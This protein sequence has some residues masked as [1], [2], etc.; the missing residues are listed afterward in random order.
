M[1]CRILTLLFVSLSAGSAIAQSPSNLLLNPALN[2]HCF[3]NSR[4]GEGA[5]FK[6]GSIACWDV[7]TYGDAEAYRAARQQVFRPGFAVD[8]VMVIHPGKSVSQ[9]ALLAELGLDGGEH[10]SLS[11]FGHQAKPKSLRASIHMMRLDSDEGSWSPKE[12]GLSD[13]R[14]FPKHSRGELTALPTMASVSGEQTD[15]ELKVEKAMIPFGFTESGTTSTKQPNVIGITVEFTNAGSEDVWIYS[16]CLARGDVAVN[17]LPE[18]RAIPDYYRGIPR[19]IQKLWR[20]EPLHLIVMGSSIDRGSANP[21]MTAY[22]EAPKSPTF[23][24]PLS[25]VREFEGDVVG[26][27][28]WNDYTGWWQ[29]HYMYGGRLR[30]WLMQ[31]FNYPIDRLLLNTMACDGSC[32]AESHSGLEAYATLSLPPDPGA[33]GHAKSKTWQELYPAVFSR[34][35]G[36]RPDLV[37]FGSG[38]NE[39]VDG[40]DEVAAF[41]GAIR[42]FQRHYPGT[43]FVFCMWQN[44]E[45]Y[46]PNTGHLRELS[47]RYQ[48]PF[49]DL[50]RV[51]SETTRYCNSYALVPSDGHPQAAAHYLWARQLERAFEVADP[52]ASGIAQLSLPERLSPHTIGWEGEVTTYNADDKRLHGNRAFILDDTFVNVWATTKDD[53]VGIR[54]DGAPDEASRRRPSRA[55]DNRNSTF[56]T[57]RFSLGDRHIIEVTGKDSALVAVD[58]KTALNR[59]TVPVTGPRWKLPT[60]LE[61]FA[62]EWGAPFGDASVKLTPGA[63]AI[64]DFIGT[65]LSVAYV[66]AADGGELI[67]T[68]DGEERLKTSTNTA[69]TDADGKP[70]FMENRKGIR[71]LPYGWHQV[72][73]TCDG[74]PVRLLG[75]FT[76]DT[77]PNRQAERVERGRAFP[78]ETIRFTAGFKSRPWIVCSGGLQVKIEDV[79]AMSVKFTG[80]GEGGYEVIGE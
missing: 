49:I 9:F 54:L 24:Q 34:P 29:H 12:F 39:K 68:V 13:A 43:E 31:K 27:P 80:T 37:I 8:N 79:N 41:E 22:D 21:P 64:T 67:V 35:E 28:E 23:K 61:P 60:K 36:A 59:Q 26:H 70:H 78:G 4:T 45:T 16:P 56:A 3:T 47:L 48:I 44:R 7:A 65:D 66:D 53:L 11:V 71:G 63:S 17:R 33:N 75:A 1:L 76:Y 69:F 57:G 42:W 62:S 15:F 58:A 19:T 77:R 40:A 25:K 73:V 5:E 50:G 38:A 32:I 6:S 14:T 72:C 20:G 18:G 51:I 10:V 52:I 46:T 2:F 55:R 30:Q 74:K